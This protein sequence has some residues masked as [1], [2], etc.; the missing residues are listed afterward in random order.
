MTMDITATVV[1]VG[2]TRVA[3]QVAYVNVILELVNDS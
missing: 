1:C 2:M 3:T